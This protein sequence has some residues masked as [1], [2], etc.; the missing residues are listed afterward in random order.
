MVIEKKGKGTS[1]WLTR[2]EKALIE[3]GKDLFTRFTGAKISDGAYLCA[4]SMGALS[5]KVIEGI[6]IRCPECGHEVEMTMVNPR[7]KLPRK[8]QQGRSSV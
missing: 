8:T 5:V 2:E 4:L 7:V 1:I 3:E 6:L